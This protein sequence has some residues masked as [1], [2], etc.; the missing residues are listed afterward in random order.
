VHHFFLL[1]V[2]LDITIYLMTL[3]AITSLAAP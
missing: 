2:W 3:A 1:A